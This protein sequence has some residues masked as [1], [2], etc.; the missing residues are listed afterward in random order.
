M[1]YEILTY[2][3]LLGREDETKGKFE[4]SFKG[5]IV[6]NV[7]LLRLRIFNSGNLAVLPNDFIKPLQV[8]LGEKVNVLTA[9]VAES[10]PNNLQPELLIKGDTVRVT[11]TLF[12][13]GDS[14]TVR[15]LTSKS[16]DPGKIPPPTVDGHIVE[17]TKIRKYSRES[18]MKKHL[19]VYI[20]WA[21]T[22]TSLTIGLMLSN[23]PSSVQIPYM[24]VILAGTVLLL[25]LAV[26][27]FMRLTKDIGIQL[28]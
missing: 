12:N 20:A 7:R 1:S 25:I 14:I 11:P 9:E 8:H 3:P 13:S 22:F 26:R 19:V 23:L 28:R 5:V 21:V 27:D 24:Q 18:S 2:E 6:E 17:V 16:D 10:R 4:I 15:V